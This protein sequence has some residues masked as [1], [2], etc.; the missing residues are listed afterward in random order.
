M[1]R[2][3]ILTLVTV[4]SVFL[5]A[6]ACVSYFDARMTAHGTQTKLIKNFYDGDITLWS[7]LISGYM[8]A[9]VGAGAALIASHWAVQ[10]SLQ[11]AELAG[12]AGVKAALAGAKHANELQLALER[13]RTDAAAVAFV[14]SVFAELE[15]LWQVVQMQI[16]P[17]IHKLRETGGGLNVYFPVVTDYFVVYSASAATLGSVDSAAL[18]KSIV[19]VYVAA[20]AFVDT[21]RMNNGLVQRVEDASL[22]GAGFSPG[23]RAVAQ[24][25]IRYDSALAALKTYASGVASFFSALESAKRNFDEVANK[26][27]EAK[28]AAKLPPTQFAHVA[29]ILPPLNAGFGDATVGSPSTVGRA[30]PST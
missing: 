16:A 27:L 23:D 25:R 11:A 29:G 30:S 6:F 20:R 2:R 17:A 4:L 22:A 9:L 21:I 5:I 26:W 13:E 7:A 19:S 24:A 8:S 14:Q 1:R 10:A 3:T 18:R 12:K 15:A 28:G